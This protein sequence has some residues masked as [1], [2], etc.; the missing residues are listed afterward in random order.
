M[1]RRTNNMETYTPIELL[2]NKL[3]ELNSISGM[4]PNLILEYEKAIMVLEIIGGIPVGDKVNEPVILNNLDSDL[5]NEPLQES[6][7]YYE[8]FMEAQ[9]NKN[10]KS[11]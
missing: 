10:T 8:K 1:I 3:A 2:K 5:N 9:K 11:K 7:S 6:K 4:E